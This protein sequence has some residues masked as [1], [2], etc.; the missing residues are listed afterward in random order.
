M[1]HFVNPIYVHG[2]IDDKDSAS[3]NGCYQGSDYWT[4]EKLADKAL[5]RDREY[6][7]WLM[8]KNSR[9][10]N[11]K[12]ELLKAENNGYKRKLEIL[13]EQIKN[14]EESEFPTSET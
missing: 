4:P 5:K 12:E 1:G 10:Q 7:R 9:L 11:L 14:I 6:R 13:R 3:V 8:E 2:F